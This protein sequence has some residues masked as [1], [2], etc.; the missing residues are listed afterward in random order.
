MSSPTTS[1]QTPGSTSTAGTERTDPVQTPLR[2]GL[3]KKGATLTAVRA[4]QPARGTL[5]DGTEIF[6]RPG[7]WAIYAGTSSTVVAVVGAAEFPGPYEIVAEGTL[8]LSRAERELIEA[9]T[10]V[11]TTQT[12]MALLQAVQRLARISIGDVNIP[13]TPGQMEELKYRAE[14]R[15]QT[16]A[17]TLQAVVDRI[18]DEIFHRG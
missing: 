3:R 8:T 6:V 2:I 15:G 7:D 16:V 10:G 4:T 14:K 5:P 1:P 11:G 18:R 12:A 13:F 9:T 17:Q